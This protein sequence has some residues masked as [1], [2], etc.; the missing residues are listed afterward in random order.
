MK[1]LTIM[2]SL[3]SL[4]LASC[5][6]GG[7]TASKTADATARADG[8]MAMGGPYSE[9]ETRMNEAMMTAVGVD[10]G[11]SWVRKMI[12]HHR[13]AIEMSNL[14]LAQ[15]PSADV[16]KMARDVIAKQ[17]AEIADLEK[18]VTSGNPIAASAA[19][20]GAAA[21]AMHEAMMAAK[22]ADAS[23]IYLRKMLAHHNGAIAMSE[24]V[25]AQQGVTPAIRVLAEKV[26]VDQQR[27]V[28][29]AESMLRGEPMNMAKAMPTATASPEP[30]A[31]V[32][33]P[34]AATPR[35][36]AAPKPA[37]KPKPPTPSPSPSDPH[38]GMDM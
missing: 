18:L 25:L 10:V 11:D 34:P 31:R 22:G 4:T 33:T 24:V 20:F 21:T 32:A 9:A 35:P 3:L 15:N 6:S 8:Q 38:A 28:A 5:G 30:K 1:S 14:V 16:A 13:G 12:A 23:E 37:P 19:P 27:E 26:R 36:T 2:V 17:T 7:D 29:M